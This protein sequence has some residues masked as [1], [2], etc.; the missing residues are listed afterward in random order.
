MKINTNSS[1]TPL[2]NKANVFARTDDESLK[3]I[4]EQKTN[5][6][7]TDLHPKEK[8]NNNTFDLSLIEGSAYEQ[9]FRKEDLDFTNMSTNE[10][11]SI[12]KN[13]N[14]MQWEYTQKYGS[15]EPIRLGR[16]GNPI[17]SE[18]REDMLNLESKLRIL[19][20]AGGNVDPDKKIDIMEYLS[21]SSE[22]SDKLAKEYPNRQDYRVAA[23][24]MKEIINTF[25][26]FMSDDTFDLYQEKAARLLTDEKKIDVFI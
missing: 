4:S 7:T 3:N 18:K 8:R 5:L 24:Y 1:Q 11:H 14:E 26:R 16:Y 9:I 12:V 2:E 25:D 6:S 10:L 20:Y 17:H 15:D 21:N 23:S 13:V 19:S 22:N